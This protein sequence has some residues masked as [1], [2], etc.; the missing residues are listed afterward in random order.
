M[1]DGA[2]FWF[3]KRKGGTHH[4]FEQLMTL[5]DRNLSPSCL[6]IRYVQL[7]K[8]MRQP[9]GPIFLS[10][11]APFKPLTADSIGRITKKLL[12]HFGVPVSVLVL[13]RLVEPQ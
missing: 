10:L 11:H 1:Q 9:G 2:L 8:A 4:S 13:I 5:P 6:L 7:T 3:L 12:K